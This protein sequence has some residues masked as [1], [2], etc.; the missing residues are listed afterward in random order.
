MAKYQNQYPS[1]KFSCSSQTYL[2]PSMKQIEA[3]RILY[4]KVF[5][6]EPDRIPPTMA[7]IGK[8]IRHLQEKCDEGSSNKVVGLIQIE[9]FSNGKIRYTSFERKEELENSNSFHV[10]VFHMIQDYLKNIL[11]NRK[12]K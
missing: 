6:V 4:H 11:K 5:G 10:T 12:G 7:L 8:S 1:S 3:F 9:L 2:L